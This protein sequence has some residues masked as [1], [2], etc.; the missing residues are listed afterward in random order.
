M[1]GTRVWELGSPCDSIA[2][3]EATEK[4]HI[5]TV[6]NKCLWYVV[7]WII[8]LLFQSYFYFFHLFIILHFHISIFLTSIFI[9]SQKE[10][11]NIWLSIISR[12]IFYF[13]VILMG[14]NF[15]FFFFVIH[16]LWHLFI[17][18]L[19]IVKLFQ[20]FGNMGRFF[21]AGILYSILWYS[22]IV[23]GYLILT[24]PSFIILVVNPKRY[25]RLGDFV[26]SFWEVYAT[27]SSNYGIFNNFYWLS[28]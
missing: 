28:F 27:V 3:R 22:S 24:L 6:V 1:I 12:T 11:N 19:L 7:V 25:R 17:V 2:Q 10:T 4:V 16:V 20:S 13:P 15:L 5:T 8:L 9:Q 21:G 23:A 18:V 14:F 26:F